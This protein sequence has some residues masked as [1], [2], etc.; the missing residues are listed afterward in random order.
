[1]RKKAVGQECDQI[2]RNFTTLAKK[3][4]V[5]GKFLTVYFLCGKMLCLLWQI[6]A[7][8][9][10]IFIVTNGQILKSNLTIWSHCNGEE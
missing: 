8:I 7:I 9:G 2:W 6:C 10:L 3:L 4:Q 5:F 1:M